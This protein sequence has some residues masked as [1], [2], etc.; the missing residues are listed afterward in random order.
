MTDRL[1]NL[2]LRQAWRQA[3]EAEAK[4]ASPK[5]EHPDQ[6]I[7]T[8]QAH[9]ARRYNYWLGG[10]DNFAADRDS[11]KKI[12]EVFPDARTGA[13]AN[14][15]M[16]RRAVAYLVTEAGIRQFLD[17]GTGLPTADNTH[18]VA[19]ALAP[20]SRI[21]YVDNDP[22]VM[23]QARA[24]LTSSK[25]GET[26]YIEADIRQPDTILGHPVLAATLDLT[27]PVAVIL[28]AVLH[29]VP[30]EGAAQPIVEK[31]MQPMTAGSHLLVSH[32]TWDF[33]EKERIE[34]YQKLV[35][36]GKADI[37]SRGKDEFA[38][39]FTGLEMV[40]PGIVPIAE[41]RPAPGVEVPAPDV[42]GGWAAVGQK[43]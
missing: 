5:S 34:A 40:D 15:D 38:A 43:L 8:T 17:I 31:L 10:K 18:E 36:A 35:D 22:M 3:V 7:D 26:A 24:L 21:V 29:F 14:R 6:T 28:G 19:Q 13:R 41:W 4:M 42:I 27:K 25:P 23:T 16:L 11:A 39:L 32:S 30:G 20:E 33:F 12:E 9:P 2:T 37:Y 1:S